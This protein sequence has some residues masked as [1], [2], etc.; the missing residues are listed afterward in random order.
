MVHRV[1]FSPEA[2]TQL[3]SIYA[4]IADQANL[5][6]ALAFTGSI[7]DHCESFATFPHRGTSRDDLRPGL[8]TIGFRRLVTIAFVVDDDTVSIIG[9]FY[10]GQ[11]FEAALS[12]DVGE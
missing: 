3:L 1:V 11:D 12:G 7:V 6:I 5:E 9:V 4:Y 2:S 8:R 10:G